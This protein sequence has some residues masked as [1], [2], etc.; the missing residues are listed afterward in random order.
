MKENVLVGPDYHVSFDFHYYSVPHVLVKERVTVYQ[1]GHLIEIYHK[2]KHVARHRKQPPNYRHTTV[3]EHMPANHRFVKGMTPSWLIFKGGEI[4]AC[5][6]KAIK[7]ILGSRRHPEQGFRAA[8]GLLRLAKTYSPER[9]ENSCRR[10][11]HFKSVSYRSVKTILEKRL[12]AQPIE[13]KAGEHTPIPATYHENLRGEHFYA[14][15]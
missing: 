14:Q 7:T 12:D 11:L 10:A 2:G 15:G 6:A 1:T 9:L 3:T 13:N 5:V 8:L 4:G